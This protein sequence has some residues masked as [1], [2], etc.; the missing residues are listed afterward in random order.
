MEGQIEEMFAALNKP[1]SVL[2]LR[3]HDPSGRAIEQ[4]I[5]RRAQIASGVEINIQ[6]LAIHVDDIRR[7]N[8]P[9]RRI[10]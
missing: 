4:D 3:D 10:E 5:H 1:I 7:F 2:F 6:R 9:P 8:L